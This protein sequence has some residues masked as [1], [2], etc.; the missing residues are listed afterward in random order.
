MAA[1]FLN[2]ALA[3]TLICVLPK[4]RVA[5][6]QGAGRAVSVVAARSGELDQTVRVIGTL[7]AKEEVLVHA[8]LDSDDH[9]KVVEILAEAGDRVRAGQLLARLDS[10]R[11][12]IELMQ[13]DAKVA[14]ADAAIKQALSQ[15]EDARAVE[16]QTRSTRDRSVKL[17]A[18]GAVS[19]QA[20]EENETALMRAISAVGLA[21][22]TLGMAQADRLLAEAE[23]SDVRSRLARTSI[24]APNAGF[25]IR[26]S[27][28]LGALG[29]S[30]TE[31]FFSIARDG[32]V[33]LSGEV[34]QA[35]FSR[36]QDNSSARVE[37]LDGRAPVEGRVRLKS[38]ELSAGSRLGRIR[39][40]MP[41]PSGIFIGAF[42]RADVVVK[43]AIGVIVPDT[44]VV[45]LA[46]SDRVQVISNGKIQTRV[47]A[48]GVRSNGLVQLNSGLSAGETVVLKGDNF[49]SEGEP[50]TPVKV[51]FHVPGEAQAASAFAPVA[52][53]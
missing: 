49:L 11:I 35:E 26:R 21:Q 22:Q 23:R 38:A 40:S 32:D 15:I 7:V 36:I 17:Q 18:K 2:W 19:N 47:V 9:A 3:L 42:A 52:L 10:S 45:N 4:V 33:E 24:I 51:V 29:S 44:S 37:L 50:I 1:K 13:S 12:E 53:Q 34:A 43:R 46:G 31:A 8:G 20:L 25:I 27:V 5:G 16:V 28:Q 14:R 6:A 39:I 48:I 41:N 30:S